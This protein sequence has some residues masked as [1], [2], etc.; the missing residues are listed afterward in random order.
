MIDIHTHLLPGVDDGSRS[1]AASL[2]VLEAFARGGVE[3][4]VCSPHLRASQA[5]SAPYARHSEILDQLI[6]A[7][8]VSPKLL[9]GWEIMLDVAGVDLTDPRYALGG[10]TAVL[11]EFPHSLIP[12][13]A[14]AELFRL[15]MSGIV[16]VVAHPERYPGCTPAIVAEWRRAGAVMQMNVTAVVGGRRGKLATQLLSGGLIDLFASDTHCDPRSLMPA[17]QWLLE[18]AGATH[19]DL[20]TREN[21]NRLL[22]NKSLA[23]VPPFPVELGMFQRLRELVRGFRQVS[24]V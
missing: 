17:R 16:P 21:A 22:T 11:V 23:P 4:V 9:L 8:A 3:T 7:A 12:P 15:R 6:D 1:I 14:A 10:S 5:S 18:T 2:P 24:A 20:L 19:A 13:N